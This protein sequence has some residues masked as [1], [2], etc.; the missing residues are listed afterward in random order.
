MANLKL[1]IVNPNLKFNPKISRS[2]VVT[3]NPW[4]TDGVNSGPHTLHW[5][6]KSIYFWTG[7]MFAF[8][9]HCATAGGWGYQT[10][11]FVSSFLRE[12]KSRLNLFFL[13]A[14][15]PFSWLSGSCHMKTMKG[16]RW[17]T[18]KPTY[19]NSSLS[20]DCKLRA[21][22]F[23]SFQASHSKLLFCQSFNMHSCFSG[24]T[25]TEMNICPKYIWQ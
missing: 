5:N 18:H 23:L 7:R 20:H 10:G 12:T 21:A 15:V 1:F 16:T 14:C 17:K 24:N 2:T 11:G 8:L 4:L 25:Q 19:A 22:L 9:H 6:A 3:L 13:F